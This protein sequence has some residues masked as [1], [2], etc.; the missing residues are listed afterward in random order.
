MDEQIVVLLIILSSIRRKRRIISNS[1]D[2]I[3]FLMF[4]FNYT[5]VSI[6]QRERNYFFQ[7]LQRLVKSLQTNFHLILISMFKNRLKTKII[8]NVDWLYWKRY[9]AW[10]M[11]YCADITIRNIKKWTY[12][13]HKRFYKLNRFSLR[14]ALSKEWR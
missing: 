11:W 7:F 14:L 3:S 8:Y 5:F 2:W 13:N 6:I 1:T 12:H 9:L 10:E 4:I